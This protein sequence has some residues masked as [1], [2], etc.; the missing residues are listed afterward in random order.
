M[1]SSSAA[2]RDV[3]IATRSRRLAEV[4][5]TN[6]RKEQI[7]AIRLAL[8]AGCS[9]SE[10]AQA[11]GVTRQWINQLQYDQGSGSDVSPPEASGSP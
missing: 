8:S 2:L 4:D 1:I 3:E 10:V 9:Q 7:N 5:F 6:A 11:A